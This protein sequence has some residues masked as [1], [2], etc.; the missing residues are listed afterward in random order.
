MRNSIETD[1]K[2][3]QDYI[4]SVSLKRVPKSKDLDEF[5]VL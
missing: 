2:S 1:N 4:V 5:I 3:T